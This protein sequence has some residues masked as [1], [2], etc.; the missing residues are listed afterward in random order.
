MEEKKKFLGFKQVTKEYYDALSDAEKKSYIWLVRSNI[1]K[2]DDNEEVSYDADIFFGTRRYAHV[3]PT[4]LNI[5]EILDEIRNDISGNTEN[6]NEI[7]EILDSINLILQQ[8]QA[9][10]T[11]DLKVTGVNV[12]NLTDGKEF[13]S[14]STIESLLRAML[15]KTIGVTPHKPTSTISIS[16]GATNGGTYEVGTTR[17]VSFT[18]GY[19][20]GYFSGDEGYTYKLD[21]GCESGTT[22][23][24]SGSTTATTSEFTTIPI[25]VTSS[26][27]KTFYFRNTIS[28][29]ESN[30]EPVDNMGDKTNDKISSGTTSS[31]TVSFYFKYKYFLGYDDVTTLEELTSDSIRAL[32]AKTDWCTT[33]GTTTV[34]GSTPIKS[35][36][37][38]III[39]CPSK[40]KLNT[41]QNGIGGD[42][43]GNFSVSGT[44]TVKTGS[45]NSVYNVYIYPITNNTPVEFKNLTLK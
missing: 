9:V 22:K 15:M 6:I 1:V 26:T 44:V 35:D 4:T 31:S 33:N 8:N 10:L 37:K 34:V 18:S 25:D 5:D 40:Y 45:E 28:Y 7:Y 30:A 23:W 16:S 13:A 12:G 32:S 21:A 24:Y 38:S 41:I 20:D 11:Q 19:T 3:T 36:G 29:G 43:K 39:A 17:T 2:N 14:G 42:I 27:E